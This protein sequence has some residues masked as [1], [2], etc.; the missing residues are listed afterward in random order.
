[1]GSIGAA[2]LIARFAFPAL[3]VL[4]WMR[5]AVGATVT[6][7]LVALAIAAYTVFPRVALGGDGLITTALA[8]LDIVL[9]FIVFKGDVR[10]T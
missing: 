10:I 3:L 8:V 9:V 2:A 7:I 4:G 6:I 1:M 5:G